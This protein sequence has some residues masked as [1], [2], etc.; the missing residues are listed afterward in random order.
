MNKEHIIKINQ[1]FKQAC[2]CLKVTGF[3]F[4]VMN[5]KAPVN[6]ARSFSVGYTNLKT[7]LIAIDIFTPKRRQ[8]KSI[9]TILRI[10][11]HEIAHHQKKPYRQLHRG[12]WITR[13]HYP[14]FYKQVNKNIEKFKKDRELGEYFRK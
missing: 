6:T 14:R 4:R 12:R 13:S 7:K 1:I 2:K 10:L 11:A 5:R 9:N 3:T 8:P